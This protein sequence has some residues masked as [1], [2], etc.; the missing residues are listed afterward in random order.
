M[1]PFLAAKQAL[2]FNSSS[3]LPSFL[4]PKEL[5]KQFCLVD[6]VDIVDKVDIC[7]L[8]DIVDIVDIADIGDTVNIVERVNIFEIVKI[9]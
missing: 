4:P 6:I 8:V 2:H 7:G 5:A 1:P 9:E 3:C